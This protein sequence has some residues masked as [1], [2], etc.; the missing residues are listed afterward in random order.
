MHNLNSASFNF[1]KYIINTIYRNN[2]NFL[3]S[4]TIPICSNF[5]M[6]L[7]YHILVYGFVLKTLPH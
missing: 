3:K 4:R 6:I 5:D 1:N 2:D 7:K